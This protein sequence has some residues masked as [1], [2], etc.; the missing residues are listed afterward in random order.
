MSLGGANS[1][2][3]IKFTGLPVTVPAD[4]VG[5]TFR[6]WP[7][8][9]GTFRQEVPFPSVVSPNPNTA[10]LGYGTVRLWAAAGGRDIWRKIETSAG[11]YDF[12][13]MDQIITQ[14][15]TDGKTI[16]LEIYGPPS[17]YILSTDAN[18]S[19][20]DTFGLAGGQCYPGAVSTSTGGTGGA[21]SVTLAV[22]ASA[23]G[24]TLAIGTI[25]TG[26]G[27]TEN[28]TITGNAGVTAGVG[29]YTMSQAN[30]IAAA[31]QIT[32]QLGLTRLKN[33]ISAVVTRYNVAGGAWKVANP[34]LG[35]GLKY[36]E[37]WN[38]T[39]NPTN[40]NG[41]ASGNFGYWT[42]TNNQLVDCSKVVHATAKALDPTI[43]ILSPSSYDCTWTQVYLNAAGTVYPTATGGNVCDAVAMHIYTKTLP[44]T[45]FSDGANPTADLLNSYYEG[46]KNIKFV[47]SAAGYANIPIYITEAG[48]G[49]TV[50]GT[51]PI[52]ALLLMNNAGLDWQYKHWARTMMFCAAWGYKQFVTYCWERP[53]ACDMSLY[54]NEG[55][56]KALSTIHASVAGKTITS[57]S[58]NVGGEVT[59]NFSDSTSL[60]V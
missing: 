39:V 52:A 41:N 27:V 55:P 40:A 2:T 8:T 25:I 12:T 58:F 34:T 30:T 11:V 3:G 54:P 1:L 42:G 5:M 32:A 18:K 24:L 7:I 49:Y 23:S 16:M 22:T 4:F 10:G 45:T 9:D 28:T 29:N 53:F 35:N 36:L 50:D 47:L 48:F 60:T 14:H 51:G 13:F 46:Y 33:Y 31:T 57:G 44:Y 19:V 56:Q 43:I 17:D 6:G 37:P 21:S 15:R 59:L 20:L 26:T 38:E